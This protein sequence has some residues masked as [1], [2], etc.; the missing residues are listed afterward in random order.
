MRR[1]GDKQQTKE[2]RNKGE[3]KSASAA[4]Q[5]M[6]F[7]QKSNQTLV[8]QALGIFVQT[9]VK[10]GRGGEGGGAQPKGNHQTDNEHSADPALTG[11]C[12]AKLHVRSE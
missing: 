9:M 5:Q 1:L 2:E 3:Q 4:R 11:H 10:L 7:G 8:V 12:Y 6:A